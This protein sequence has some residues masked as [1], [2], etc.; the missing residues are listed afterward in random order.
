MDTQAKNK[1]KNKN[2]Y[3]HTKGVNQRSKYFTQNCLCRA[4]QERDCAAVK[5]IYK[6]YLIVYKVYLIIYKVYLP[7]TSKGPQEFVLVT[8]PNFVLVT[9]QS[10]TYYIYMTCTY[11]RT[12]ARTHAHTH[13]STHSHAHTHARTHARTYTH[14]TQA[15]PKP[16]RN[17]NTMRYNTII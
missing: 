12:L 4:E 6:V 1:L 11:M 7:V 17:D 10:Y 16:Q 3:Q 14:T 8:F 9:F 15:T 2:K 13:A 5:I